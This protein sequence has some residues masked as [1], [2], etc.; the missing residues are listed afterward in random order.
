MS[1]E[2]TGTGQNSGVPCRVWV[3]ISL[4]TL[5]RNFAKIAEKV[6]PCG[7]IAV[8]KANAYGL[9]VSAIAEALCHEG[10]S[11][12]AVAELNEALALRR[13]GLPV[14]ILGSV[15]PEEI[16]DSVAN[17]VILP[18]TDLDTARAISR[19]AVRQQRTA[20]CEFLVDTGMGRLG[21]PVDEAESVICESA[22]LPSL[23]C[24]GIYSH[25]PM[26]Y[27]SGCDYT[28]GQIRGFTRLLERLESLDLKFERRHIANS[29]AINNF[30]ETYRPPFNAVRT[31]INLHGS[32]DPEGRRVLDVRPVLSLKTR[33]TSVR[34]L[35]AG[36]YIG[37]GCTYR[38]P[39]DMLVG[40]VSAGYADGLPLALSNRGHV[41]IRGRTC[42]VLGRVSMDYTTV[43]LEQ[44]P[45][46][47]CGD[48]V[49]CIG[50]EGP[51]AIRVEDW[52]MLKGTHAYE[53]ICSFGSRVERRCIGEGT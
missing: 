5:R 52:A 26:A 2:E 40:T 38:L 50:G 22:R 24:Q 8:L 23:V 39:G 20:A 53:I 41:L 9:G 14:Q 36:T 30:P 25:F 17:D 44:V 37:Y 27:R 7:V 13:F 6:A 21:V 47:Q 45:D 51:N 48:D 4:P 31:G 35:K 1:T 16:P 3:E 12:F 18:V 43:S 32:F 19:E 34:R 42:Q 11:A 29:D 28:T 49:V 46:A 33:L 10:A 15:L